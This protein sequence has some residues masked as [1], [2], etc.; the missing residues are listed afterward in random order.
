MFSRMRQISPMRIC[1]F[2][3]FR[4]G[5]VI[6]TQTLKSIKNREGRG[7]GQGNGRERKIEGLGRKEVMKREGIDGRSPFH[8]SY[9][10]VTVSMLTVE[11]GM[12]SAILYNPATPG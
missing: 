2:E 9:I 7:I 6:R 3:N 12:G 1:N 5:G 11:C 4:G 8:K 10:Y